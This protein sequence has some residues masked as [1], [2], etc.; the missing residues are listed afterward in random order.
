MNNNRY[1]SQMVPTAQT[2]LDVSFDAPSLLEQME[3][4][5]TKAR[6]STLA[7]LAFRELMKVS[8]LSAE[9]QETCVANVCSLST[10]N[11]AFASG[12]AERTQVLAV[13][14]SALLM[15]SKITRATVSERVEEAMS[16]LSDKYQADW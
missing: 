11:A 9:E 4:R 14:A 13:M 5:S 10:A 6:M 3:N 2:G 12:G 1:I 7:A 8:D 15:A 16:I